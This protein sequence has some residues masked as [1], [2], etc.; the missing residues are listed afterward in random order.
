MEAPGNHSPYFV[1]DD[2]ALNVGLKA[3]VYLV[4]DYPKK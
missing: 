4:L 1:V 3:L 2:R